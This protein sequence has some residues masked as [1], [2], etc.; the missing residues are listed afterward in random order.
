V[1]RRSAASGRYYRPGAGV[2]R[3]AA[4]ELIMLAGP[5]RLQADSN[6]S[7]SLASTMGI[8]FNARSA[9]IIRS[10]APSNC[11]PQWPTA[12]RLCIIR[13]LLEPQSVELKPEIRESALALAWHKHGR[14]V[15]AWT[16][17]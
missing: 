15:N 2:S 8:S 12:L 16:A 5:S 1:H 4:D 7:C 13:I 3:F 17:S 6:R 9:R 14:M 11:R 10:L